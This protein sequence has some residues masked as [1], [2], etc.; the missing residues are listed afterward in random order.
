MDWVCDHCYHVM[1]VTEETRNRFLVTCPNCGT[2]WYV[3]KDDEILNDYPTWG[4]D[5]EEEDE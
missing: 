5:D 4:P 2:Y 1:E 3:D